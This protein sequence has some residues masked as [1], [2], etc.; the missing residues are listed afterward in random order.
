MSVLEILMNKRKA[1]ITL[2]I[3]VLVFISFLSSTSAGQ[4]KEEKESIRA[5]LIL[6]DAE[7]ILGKKVFPYEI[8][9]VNQSEKEVQISKKWTIRSVLFYKLYDINMKPVGA[10]ECG[11]GKGRTDVLSNVKVEIEW[12]KLT[13][14]MSYHLSEMMD[15]DVGEI[16]TH[17]IYEILVGIKGML[18][19]SGGTVQECRINTNSS[20]WLSIQNHE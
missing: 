12:V 9:I 4:K 18:K 17:G 8:Y 7:K 19:Q 6:P 1:L 14:G 16:D 13:P 20:L 5:V 11:F 2:I 15:V 3:A 10:G